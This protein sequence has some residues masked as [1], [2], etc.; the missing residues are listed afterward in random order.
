M[1][2]SRDDAVYFGAS[3]GEL[4]DTKLRKDKDGW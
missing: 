2:L 1:P 4:C 3:L